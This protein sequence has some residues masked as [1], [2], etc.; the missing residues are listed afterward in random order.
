MKP[1]LALLAALISMPALAASPGEWTAPANRLYAFDYTIPPPVAAIPALRARLE[2]DRARQLARVRREAAADAAEARRGGFPVRKHDYSQTWQ[3][4][5]SLPG[6]LSLSAAYDTYSGGAHG[7]RW[8]GAMLWDR[9]ASRPRNPLDLFTS[10]AALSAAIR[11]DFCAA[12]DR[13]RAERRGEPVKPGG[14]APFEECIDPVKQTVLLGSRSHRLFDRIGILVAP[15]EAG[16]YAEGS[17]EVTV[18]VSA[19]VLAAVRLQF[20]ASF[21]AGN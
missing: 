1:T 19:A 10:R 20:R 14:T 12:L 17:Y 5:A 21:A 18:P 4:V 11:K 15:Y 13:Q 7:M 16:P 8:S 2:A 9:K 3:V 6:W